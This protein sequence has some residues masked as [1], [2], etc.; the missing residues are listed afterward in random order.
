MISVCTGV[1][2]LTPFGIACTTGCEKPSDRLIL[3]PAAWARKPTPTSVSFFSKPAVTPLTMF[4]TSARSVPCIGLAASFAALHTSVSPLFSIDRSLPYVRVSE[5]SGPLIVIAP[6]AS[7]TSTFA[8]SGIG[9]LPMRDIAVSCS[10]S[11]DDAKNFAPDTGGARLAVGHHAARRRDDRDAEP[12]HHPRNVVL[13]LVDAQPR[14]RH[15]LDPF[16]HRPACVILERNLEH[17]LHFLARDLEAVDVAF[18]LQYLRDGQLDLGRRHRDDGLLDHLRVADARQHVGDRISHAHASPR[19]ELHAAGAHEVPFARDAGEGIGVRGLLDDISI[20]PYQLAL[21]MPGTS[22]RIANSRSLLRPRPNLRKY[23]RGRPVIAQRLRR[24]VGFALRGSCCS[25]CRAAN[26]SSSDIF[27][28]LTIAKSASRRLA[29]FFT[30]ARRFSSRLMSD[31]F[32]MVSSVLERVTIRGEQR[33]RLGVGLGARRDRDVHPA[34]HVDLVVLD[35]GKDD[36]FLDAHVEVAAPVERTPRHAAEVA[37][38]RQRDRDQAVQELVHPGL[39]QRH[40]AADR[41]ALADLEARD[42]L[43]RLGDHGLLAGQL[44]HVAG[45]VLEQLLVADRLAHT[46]VEDDL[47]DPRHL[48]RRL[49]P[50]LLGQRGHHFLPLDLLEACHRYLPDPPTSSPFDL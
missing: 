29:N 24:R 46:H 3:S 8:G 44:L 36:L 14:L 35:L 13:A 17:G 10:R 47:L 33:L 1:S 37:H 19:Y 2:T 26:R 31:S 27:V 49:V 4:A 43:L 28:L 12:V 38:S 5:P 48:H 42:R 45:G 9:W 20:H 50:E 18:V 25:F 22:P 39:A 16:D 30:S 15:A 6:G 11:G 23:P 34:Q 21:T 32:A 40:H 41:V 7:V